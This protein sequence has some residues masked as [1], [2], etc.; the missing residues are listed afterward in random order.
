MGRLICA[1]DDE[2]RAGYLARHGTEFTAR[3]VPNLP[4]AAA[5]PYENQWGKIERRVRRPVDSGGFDVP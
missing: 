5:Y 3:G 4:V 2:Y 1:R